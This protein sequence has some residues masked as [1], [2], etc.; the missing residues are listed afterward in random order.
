[1]ENLIKFLKNTFPDGIQM[2]N[3]R[4]LVG[5]SMVTIYDEDNIV[6]DYCH[7]WQYIEIFGL[8]KEQ[9]KIVVEKANGY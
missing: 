3:T 5:D 1:M 7:Y 9:F 8:S 2:F 6:V 4:N